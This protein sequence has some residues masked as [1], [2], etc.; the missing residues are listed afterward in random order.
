MTDQVIHQLR[1][2]KLSGMREH[3]EERIQEAERNDL[4]YDEFLSMIISDE[5]EMRTNRRIARL[6]HHAGLGAEKTLE[7]FDFTFSPSVNAKLIKSLATCRFIERGEGIF[8]LGPPGT[9]KTHLAKAVAHAACRKLLS[10]GFYTFYQLFAE[11]AAADLQNR[12]GVL[13]KRLLRFDLLTIDDFAFKSIDQQSAERFYT[14]VDG[15]FGQKSIILTSNRAMTDWPKLFPDP[16]IANAIMDRLA[17][18]SHQIII[19]GQSYRKKLAPKTD[20]E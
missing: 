15:R 7:T 12:I 10:V 8:L 13:M 6:L 1:A 9:G 4:S 18:T 11:L 17:H 3:L 19:K 20:N 16:I 14:I 2:L 5:L